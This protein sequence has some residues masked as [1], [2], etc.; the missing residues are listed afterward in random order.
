MASFHTKPIKNFSSSIQKLERTN[1]SATETAEELERLKEKISNWKLS[2]FQTSVI[3]SILINLEKEGI[4]TQSKYETI[5]NL[6]YDT[7]LTYLEKWTSP[8]QP[9]KPFYWIS[10]ED[11]ICWTEVINCLKIVETVD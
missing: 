9:L 8:F 5:A 10:L 1:V 4:F 6:F 11:P 7:F 3:S 2:K